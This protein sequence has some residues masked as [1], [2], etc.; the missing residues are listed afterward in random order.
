MIHSVCMEG[1]APACA[2]MATPLSEV[3]EGSSRVC[4]N[5]GE[6]GFCHA[7]FFLRLRPAYVS[8]LWKFKQL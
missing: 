2:Y 5:P 6:A 1:K 3:P 7:G 8:V 4:A